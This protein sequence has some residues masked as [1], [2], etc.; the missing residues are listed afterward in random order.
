MFRFHHVPVER[1]S[2]LP[3]SNNSKRRLQGRSFGGFEEGRGYPPLPEGSQM[4]D[5]IA[6]PIS[7]FHHVPV[8]RIS[9]PP[10]SDDSKRGLQGRGFGGFEGGGGYPPHPEWSQM[11]DMN[12]LPIS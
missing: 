5:M 9:C 11:E 12:A 8:E 4:E 1:I 2:G 7:C 3:E 6:L 10:E